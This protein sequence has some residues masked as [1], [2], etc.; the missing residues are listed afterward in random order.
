MSNLYFIRNLFFKHS[1][2]HSKRSDLL[3]KYIKSFSFH[4]VEKKSFLVDCRQFSL[5]VWFYQNQ[6]SCQFIPFAISLLNALFYST[7]YLTIW[8]G[9]DKASPY[10]SLS[11]LV[12]SSWGKP[13][14]H[15]I[16]VAANVSFVVS[17]VAITNSTAK[18]T[19]RDQMVFPLNAL[20]AYSWL[21]VV[22]IGASLHRCCALPP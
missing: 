8:A 1:S 7:I 10:I 6:R 5:F 18:P 13:S 16:G 19:S 3:T 22:L 12:R 21:A 4:I 17:T 14:Y 2:F 9:W 15:V 11:S 20:L